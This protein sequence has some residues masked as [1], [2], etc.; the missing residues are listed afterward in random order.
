MIGLDRRS[1]SMHQAAQIAQQVVDEA[2]CRIVSAIPSS[3]AGTLVISGHGND[4]LDIPDDASKISLRDV[5]DDG[6]SRC[7]P[8]YAVAQL[9]KRAISIR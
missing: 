1:V 5:L 2:R 3:L 9:L 7:A 6:L 4:L 8:A